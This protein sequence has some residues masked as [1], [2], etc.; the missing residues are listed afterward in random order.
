MDKYGI[1][2]VM[3]LASGCDEFNRAANRFCTGAVE[4]GYRFHS[5]SPLNVTQK[6]EGKMLYSQTF[7]FEKGANHEHDA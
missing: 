2:I 7:V 5:A 6:A 3:I 1:K 4:Q